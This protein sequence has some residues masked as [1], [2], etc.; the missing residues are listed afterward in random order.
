MVS[1]VKKNTVVTLKYTVTDSDGGVVDEGVE[2]LSYLHGGYEEIFPKLEDALQG[3]KV[4]ESIRV[5]LE[6]ADAYGEYDA[7]LVLEEPREE[8]P[9]DIEVGSEV[10]GAAEGGDDE[11]FI[12][13]RITDIDDEKVVLDGNHPLAGSALVFSCTVTAIREASPEEIKQ[14]QVLE[15]DEEKD[16]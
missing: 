8:F 13:Y 16:G 12:I 2:P 6:P 4:N 5:K 1:E 11:D 9:E 14:G 7:S 3:K 15:A 10:E